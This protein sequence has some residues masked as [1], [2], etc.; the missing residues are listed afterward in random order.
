MTLPRVDSSADGLDRLAALLTAFGGTTG[1]LHIE[2]RDWSGWHHSEYVVADEPDGRLP[3]VVLSLIADGYTLRMRAF[4]AENDGSI[5]EVPALVVVWHPQTD[6][7][8]H[9]L[10]TSEGRDRVQRALSAVPP[11]SVLVDA[12]PEAW[13]A[14]LLEEP[15]ATGDGIHACRVLAARL[16]SDV[17]VFDGH[18]LPVYGP[19]R[20][21]NRD[22]CEVTTIVVAN[23]SRRYSL[24]ELLPADEDQDAE[25]VRSTKPDRRSTGAH[26]KEGRRGSGR[27]VA[28]RQP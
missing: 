25:S 18:A 14:W 17:N 9:Y 7:T 4:R 1:R 8:D 26:H 2:A 3:M 5:L 16:H 27:A 22:P 11:P 6:F 20:N 12:G 28:V 21:W 19:V 15:L 13:A 24:A 23:P 10:V